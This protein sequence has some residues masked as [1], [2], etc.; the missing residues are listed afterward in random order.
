MLVVTRSAAIPV[1][2]RIVVAPITRTTR[3]IPTEIAL[4][5]EQGLPVTC[6]ASFD[7][8]QPIRPGFLTDRIGRLLPEQTHDICRALEALAD[9]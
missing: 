8:L 1:L 4:G 6:V 3:G 5:P 2:N 7:N 9:C